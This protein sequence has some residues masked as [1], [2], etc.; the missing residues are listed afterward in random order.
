MSHVVINAF[1][2][3]WDFEGP[4]AADR[5]E[6]DWM[7]EA[8]FDDEFSYKTVTEKNLRAVRQKESGGKDVDPVKQKIFFRA[9]QKALK[10]KPVKNK[11][12]VETPLKRSLKKIKK[13]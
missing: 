9:L 5:R 3:E 13:L 11:E 12:C 4:A 2:T 1:E 6:D 8:G 10:E 7:P